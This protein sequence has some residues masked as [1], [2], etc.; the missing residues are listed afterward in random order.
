MWGA[1]VVALTYKATSA[2]GAHPAAATPVKPAASVGLA[3]S[4]VNHVLVDQPTVAHA[5]GVGE[6]ARVALII[7]NGLK[8]TAATA[9]PV[10]DATI[11]VSLC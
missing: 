3:H 10:L 8:C 7:V 4:L 5:A 1:V 11:V 6:P 2:A 9:A